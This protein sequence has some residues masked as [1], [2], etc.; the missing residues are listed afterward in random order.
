MLDSA[1]ITCEDE[2]ERDA[3]QGERLDDGEAEEQVGAVEAGRLGLAGGRLDVGG[4]DEAD[5][6]AGADR[7][8][9]VTDRGE[10]AGDAS[11]EMSHSG[12]PPGCPRDVSRESCG[13][14]DDEILTV[15]G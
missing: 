13:W 14:C 15:V 8:E 10:A 1:V 2:A 4:E 11:G 3:E 7:G 6:D 9:A 5:T 12:I